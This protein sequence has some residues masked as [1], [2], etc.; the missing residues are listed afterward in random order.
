M[1]F[2]VYEFV[3]FVY[4]LYLYIYHQNSYAIN[5]IFRSVAYDCKLWFSRYVS[6]LLCVYLSQCCCGCGGDVVG[7]QTKAKSQDNGTKRL[8]SCHLSE[9]SVSLSPFC[10]SVHFV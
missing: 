1:I 8:K 2:I 4:T 6:C 10:L 5:I 9:F 7:L 3:K